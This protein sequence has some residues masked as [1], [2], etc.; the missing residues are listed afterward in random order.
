M[1]ILLV[2]RVPAPDTRY[3]YPYQTGCGLVYSDKV[4]DIVDA[5]VSGARRVLEID[6]TCAQ[7]CIPHLV[8]RLS[9]WGA[10]QLSPFTVKKGTCEDNGYDTRVADKTFQK[11]SV[12]FEVQ[13]FSTSTNEAGR[14]L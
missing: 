2:L 11:Y 1:Y 10:D 13:L 8:Y 9:L 4:G 3:L 12:V 5:Y 6:N 14:L 7:T